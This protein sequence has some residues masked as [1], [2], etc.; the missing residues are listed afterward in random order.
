MFLRAVDATSHLSENVVASGDINLNRQKVLYLKSAAMYSGKLSKIDAKDYIF[1]KL[2]D[3]QCVGA[4]AGFGWFNAAEKE[5]SNGNRA[6]ALGNPKN[7]HRRQL[8]LS[9]G[10]VDVV[11]AAGLL[12][13]S[14]SYKESEPGGPLIVAEKGRVKVAG[15]IVT[16]EGLNAAQENLPYSADNTNEV[17]SLV[18]ILNYPAIK[19]IIYRDK[20]RSENR[21]PAADGNE[22]LICRGDAPDGL[23][24][25]TGKV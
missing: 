14:G 1:F 6:T 13:F 5:L 8:H 19:A 9:T 25:Q 17:L 12:G 11:T 23:L 21:N 2:P 22:Y 16:H 3:G 24:S 4:T 20:A 10:G 18:L 7:H 15:M